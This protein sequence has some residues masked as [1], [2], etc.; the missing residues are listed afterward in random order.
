MVLFPK[1]KQEEITVIVIN[2]RIPQKNESCTWI[3]EYI[4]IKKAFDLVPHNKFLEVLYCYEIRGIA[5]KIFENY[6]FSV[7]ISR[8]MLPLHIL[9]ASD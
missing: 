1:I 6:L 7:G 8:L 3:L 4:D 2:I 9:P 5:L